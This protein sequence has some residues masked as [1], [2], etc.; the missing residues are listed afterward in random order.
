M[1][2]IKWKKNKAFPYHKRCSSQCGITKYDDWY[3]PTCDE[4]VGSAT[5]EQSMAI[6]NILFPKEE[7]RK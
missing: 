5:E 2:E 4:I 7:K 6:V 1:S 3:C